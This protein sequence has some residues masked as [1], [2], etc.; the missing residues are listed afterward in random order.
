MPT[1][2][3]AKRVKADVIFVKDRGQKFFGNVFCISPCPKWIDDNFDA[4]EDAFHDDPFFFSVG[5]MMF[6]AKR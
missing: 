6:T 2:L 1:L 3:I 4:L 5:F